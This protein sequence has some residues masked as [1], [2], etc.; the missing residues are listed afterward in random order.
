YAALVQFYKH[1]QQHGRL[2]SAQFV[3]EALARGPYFAKTLRTHARYFESNQS[4]RPS[5]YG[6]K[7][8][9]SGL[10]NDEKVME[11]VKAWL[12]TLKVGTIT[13]QLLCDR[14]QTVILP[15]H[16]FRKTTI[17]VRH[18]QRWLPRLGY[19][20][21]AHMKGIY[22][23]GHER[24][25]VQKRRKAYINELEDLSRLVHNDDP[26][27][28][29][30]PVAPTLGPDQKEHV[31]LFHDEMAIHAN[32]CRK[33]YWALPTETV[34]RKKDQGRLMMV[35]EFITSVTSSGRLVMSEDQWQKQLELPEEQRLP[36]EARVIIY[37][38]GK[39]GTDD[40]WNMKQMISQ[41][42]KLAEY[43]LPGKVLVFIF[44]NSSA[45]NSMPPDALHV[46]R[47]NI[48]PGG[49]QSHMRDTLIPSD[50]P[51]GLGG[52]AQAMQFPESLPE[53]DPHKEFEGKPK[54]IRRVLEERGLVSLER[55]PKKRGIKVLNQ[56][57]DRIIG[58]CKMCKDKKAR[59]PPPD[60]NANS[61][62]LNANTPSES[63]SD[64]EGR[65]DCCMSRMLSQQ[66]DFKGQM[67]MLEQVI[68]NAG[69]QCIFLP[70]FHCELNPIEYYWGWVKRRFRERCNGQF[71]ASKKLL[72]DSLDACP[73]EV[74]RRFIRRADRY[75]SV[76]RLGAT[77]PLAD[78]AVRKY[79]S[80][81]AV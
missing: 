5:R 18:V 28:P 71:D 50:N 74:I 14:L 24:S 17:S 41:T 40:Y 80:H 62:E 76:Y 69:H 1:R 49:A 68:T 10:M 63:E 59:K 72:T 45:H 7:A 64:D 25:D 48:G 37:P 46:L 3:S 52:T 9:L 6:Y 8:R 81:R 79:R 67:S 66:G 27:A 2:E 29:M 35:S 38:S 13:P 56:A 26:N 44:D 22:W 60:I 42:I 21:R 55:D 75:A 31:L 78:F 54:G 4:L 47:M 34:L 19:Q 32:D 12:R 77:G 57:G 73:G 30:V 16:G 58:Q 51:N 15:T 39:P 36:R 43:I 11:D 53:N 33:H 70:K 23:D 20:R 65:V 61:L